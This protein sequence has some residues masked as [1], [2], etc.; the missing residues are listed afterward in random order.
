VTAAVEVLQQVLQHPEGL[1]PIPV[2]ASLTSDIPNPPVADLAAARPANDPLAL[3][4]P[5][6]RQPE[7][8]I[9][10]EPAPRSGFV[11]EVEDEFDIGGELAALAPSPGQPITAEVPVMA[12]RDDRHQVLFDIRPEE[13]VSWRPERG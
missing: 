7:V 11:Q 6:A 3:V 1:T 9:A 12:E 2:P 4:E 10:R 8:R 13:E 5:S